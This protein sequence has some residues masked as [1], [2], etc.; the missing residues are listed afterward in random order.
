MDFKYGV[1][2][3]YLNISILATLFEG[4]SA[5]QPISC[6]I[7]IKMKNVSNKILHEEHTV[8]EETFAHY[9]RENHRASLQWK[10]TRTQFICTVRVHD[11]TI[12]WQSRLTVFWDTFSATV[13]ADYKFCQVV[14]KN[15]ICT[16]FPVLN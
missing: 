1:L 7:F 9:T 12:C 6:L 8:L 11:S 10:H 14:E 2:L 15:E 5:F 4:L 16:L 13:T 3:K